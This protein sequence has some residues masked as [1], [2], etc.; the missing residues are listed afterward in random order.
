MS[1]TG[2]TTA[3][4]THFD[5]LSP[6]SKLRVNRLCDRFEALW[7][8]TR[9]ADLDAFVRELNQQ[10][11]NSTICELVDIDLEYRTRFQQSID[12]QS[13]L[14]RFPT[15]D[16]RWLD[17]RLSL[18][19]QTPPSAE[20][21]AMCQAVFKQLGDYIV[22]GPL[23]SGG[24]GQVYRAE[25]RLMGRQVA[26]K[27]LKDNRSNDASSK[28]RF[29]REVRTIAKLSHPNVVS[30]FDA[31]EEHGTLFL[32]TELID[33]EDLASL[34]KRKG[35][36][37]PVDAMYYIWQAAKGL[38]Y[39][40]DQG[41]VHRDVKP[42]NL[43]LERKKIVKVLD[44]G[45][46]RLR[47]ADNQTLSNQHAITNTSHIVGTAA[48]MSP[49][50]ASD[51]QSVDE[52]SDIY[53][54]G[55]T[56]YYLI[57]GRP[58]YQAQSDVETILAHLQSPVPDLI[59]TEH[60]PAVAPELNALVRRMLDKSPEK[61]PTT[62]DEVIAALA[63]QIKAL[64]SDTSRL[65]DTKLNVRHPTREFL[66]ERRLWPGI[67]GVLVG[68]CV[69]VL[70]WQALPWLASSSRTLPTVP[71][72]PTRA[73]DR[74]PSE[75][76]RP[77][78]RNE[79]S[80]LRPA[81]PL[82]AERS[83][84]WQGGLNFDGQRSYVR[85]PLHG[86]RVERD[87]SIEAAVIARP[88]TQPSNI[89]TFSGA[90]C[91]VMF[92]ANRCWGVASFDGQR[93]RLIVS[94]S[95]VQYGKPTLVAGQLRDGQLT[96]WLNGTMQLSREIE[97]PM[98][99]GPEELYLGGIPDGVIPAEQGPRYFSGTI[100]AVRIQSGKLFSPAR[101][102]SE[103]NQID[104][105]TIAMFPL[106]ESSGGFCRDASSHQLRGELVGAKWSLP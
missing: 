17:E 69:L 57:A 23:G 77:R 52:R 34:I 50:Q 24:M 33:G 10:E 39:A 97:Y 3:N 14:A 27:V 82:I 20:V 85:V 40:H 66:L 78:P 31:R 90:R 1:D 102:L 67:I 59:D 6:T 35:P 60:Q 4:A 43:I 7:Q 58:P 101:T 81:I 100:F 49:E 36:L 29:E 76:D 71:P 62:M 92:I 38:K 45:L 46:A 2:K 83:S 32:V 95:Y 54:L 79:N 106:N 72:V 22:L 91:M 94:E 88:Q 8:S 42:G 28:L 44:L 75:G 26:I 12:I 80:E 13:Y 73:D 15:I 84:E 21:Q 74:E 19:N 55:C 9:Q 61:R 56:L 93:P 51:P 53:S 64:R 41:I 18:L 48:F 63:G 89:V 105:S 11:V 70:G 30:A 25:H 104:G 86:E 5:R 47:D 87:F 99:P 98:Q 37:K 96:L 68:L 16:R 65:V 103:L